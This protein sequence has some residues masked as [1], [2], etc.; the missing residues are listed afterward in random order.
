MK[1]YKRSWRRVGEVKGVE[2]YEGSW[3]EEELESGGGRGGSES[4]MGGGEQSRVQGE[5]ESG[6]SVG[7]RRGYQK[8]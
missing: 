5:V 6:G 4:T 3:E 7:N 2:G 1:G 8:R